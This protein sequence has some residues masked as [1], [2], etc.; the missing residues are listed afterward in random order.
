MIKWGK[1][2]KNLM[3]A[4]FRLPGRPGSWRDRTVWDISCR[5]KTVMPDPGGT[6]GETMSVIYQNR[7]EKC[8][9]FMSY[10][11]SFDTHLHRQAELIVVMEGKMKVTADGREYLLSVEE[12]ILIMPNQLHSL[13]TLGGSKILLCIFEPDFCPGY[14]SRIVEFAP[15]KPHFCLD[16]QS[17][18]C[19]RAV[20]GLAALASGQTSQTPVSRH[21]LAL[22]E[23]YLT[24]FLAV[25]CENL[26]W[27]RGDTPADPGLE[28]LVL[29]YVEEHFTEKLSLGL[30]SREFGVSR[31]VLSRLFTGKLH[32]SFPHY[33]NERRLAYACRLLKDTELSVTEIALD[34]GFG[35]TRSFFRAFREQ[36]GVTPGELRRAYRSPAGRF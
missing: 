26:E 36:N 18:H 20:E 9:I 14:Q 17:V 2:W 24:L 25:V 7:P 27:S 16:G 19:T 23:G 35:S 13:Q 30:L 5:I 10:N 22:A 31:F 11:N 1:D 6:K 8:Q 32:I 4:L 33:I 29:G 28:Q 15:D 21:T 34:V 3:Q 12:G